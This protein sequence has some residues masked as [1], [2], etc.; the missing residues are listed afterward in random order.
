MNIEVNEDRLI[1]VSDLHLGNPYSLATRNLPRFIDYCADGG[2]S[3]VINGDGVDILQGRMR[4]LAEQTLEVLDLLRRL[5][6]KGK[7]TYYVVGNHDT[8]L[9]RALN[10][11]LAQY[12]SPF[13]NVDSGGLRIRI[14]HG[15][16]YDAFY[17]ANPH[18]YEMLGM[19]AAPL[20]RIYP[21]TYKLWAATTRLRTRVAEW[22]TDSKLG[23]DAPEQVAAAM[24]AERGFDIVIF[25]HTHRHERVELPHGAVYFNTGNWLRNSTFVQIADGKADLLEWDGHAAR[26]PRTR[27]L[28]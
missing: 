16:V 21:D 19:A 5:E 13:L 17:A 10:T 12:L 25:G 7:H 15:H 27:N 14:E 20:L 3:L 4:R 23:L 6:A 22:M 11:W 28:A 2:Y 26:E 24:I 9:E 8:A 1:V 18:V